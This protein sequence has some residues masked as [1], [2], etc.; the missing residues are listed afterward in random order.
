MSFPYADFDET[1]AEITGTDGNIVL[2]SGTDGQC[3]SFL[4]TDET[5]KDLTF[6][7]NIKIK[8]VNSSITKHVLIG[9][10]QSIAGAP[11]EAVVIGNDSTLTAGNRNILIG[12]GGTCHA[13]DDGICIGTNSVTNGAGQISIGKDSGN[14]IHT[15]TET[16]NIGV[17]SGS[18][19]NGL[20]CIHIGKG[21][22][23]TQ[24]TLS[25]NRICIGKLA[26]NINGKE[27]IVAIGNRANRSNA[28]L[29]A[30]GIGQSAGE[31]ATGID[32]VCIGPFAGQ[33]NSGN[34]CI[35]IGRDA[36]K[37]MLTANNHNICIGY[38]AG[39]ILSGTGR[40]NSINIG[41]NAGDTDPRQNS[42]N[43]GKNAGFAGAGINS[44]NIGQLAGQTSGDYSSCIVLNAQIAN[45]LNPA[46]ANRFYVKPIR[47]ETSLTGFNTLYYN[48]TSGEVV[49]N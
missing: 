38:R 4:A 48:P 21:A 35:C 13:G 30:I 41:Q 37:N 31:N 9:T 34:Q 20:T 7:E 29:R 25:N 27:N 19:S 32:A 6:S 43:I 2:K 49:Y 22:G 17:D 36:G 8:T 45:A 23:Q 28:N 3:S 11:V 44:I 33:N 47:N 15:N 12:D 18:A 10:D 39:R 16:I 5:N 42:I 24:A 46:G 40:I 14:N 1:G 26:G